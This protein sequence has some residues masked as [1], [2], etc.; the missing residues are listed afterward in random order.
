MHGFMVTKSL[1]QF[2][3]RKEKKCSLIRIWNSSYP[4]Y[5]YTLGFILVLKP[6]ILGKTSCIYP[7]FI[8]HPWTWA[9]CHFTYKHISVSKE[10][11]E[12]GCGKNINAKCKSSTFR[13][14]HIP[15]KV[16]PKRV[17]NIEKMFGMCPSFPWDWLP[18]VSCCY[19]FT[20]KSGSLGG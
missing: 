7:V 12:N 18:D 14:A 3:S 1:P 8:I 19:S 4:Q 16:H 15:S 11:N 17:F 6:W 10:W 20:L 2:S 9:Y 5:S 13:L